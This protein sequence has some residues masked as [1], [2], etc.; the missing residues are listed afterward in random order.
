MMV[1]DGWDED[2]YKIVHVCLKNY[3]YETTHKTVNYF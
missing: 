3:K 2:M 1:K